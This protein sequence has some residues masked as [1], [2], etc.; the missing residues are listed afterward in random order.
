MDITKE[1]FNIGI[2]PV[3]TI[4]DA[5]K[6][7]DLAKAVSDGGI[8]CLEITFRTG[9][10]RQAIRN[11][12]GAMPE[13][14]VGAGTVLS[15]SQVDEAQ[16]AGAKFIVSP[17]FNPKVVA[18]CIDCGIPVYPGCSTPS[19]IEKAL[20][21]GLTVVKLFPAE[22]LGGIDYINTISAPYPGLKFI[23]TGG[24]REERFNYYLSSPKIIAC[25]GSWIATN[26]M[27]NESKFDLITANSRSAV[28]AALGFKL[29][30]IAPGRL[31]LSSTNIQRTAHYL[32]RRGIEYI[33]TTSSDAE[34]S[35]LTL[36]GEAAEI[37]TR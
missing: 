31:V 8:T 9:E 15:V 5:A 25:G 28:M 30:K 37:I 7:V 18:H 2:I 13:I 10:A 26:D 16:S 3:I 24:I 11:I 32:S 27:I 21:M 14:L 29:E 35:S 6:A 1:L 19:D 33:A 20:E 36:N 4:N 12:S 23:P 17:G 22:Q 34:I